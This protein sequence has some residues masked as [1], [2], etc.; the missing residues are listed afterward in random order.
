MNECVATIVLTCYLEFFLTICKKFFNNIETA[1][2]V[3]HFVLSSTH[4]FISFMSGSVDNLITMY[5]LYNYLLL[6]N[7]KLYKFRNLPLFFFFILTV[8]NLIYSNI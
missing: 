8:L 4:S 1:T 2:L 3:L 6:F 5:K 7:Y